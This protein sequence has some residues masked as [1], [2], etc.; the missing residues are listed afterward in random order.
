MKTYSKY[1]SL[2]F[3]CMLLGACSS[4]ENAADLYRQESPLQAD[5]T[6]PEEF[7]GGVP[8]KIYLTQDEKTIDNADFVHVEIWKSDGS[9]R[10]PME[11]A[12]NAGNGN[13]TFDKTLTEDG[14]YYIKVHAGNN[15]STIMPTLPFAVGELSK[16]DVKTLEG[17]VPDDSGDHSGH[18]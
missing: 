1:F 17:Q 18:H 6:M 7:S 15:G 8:I 9:F 4:K 13:Y 16:D 2:I 10:N 3:I 14:L 5:I 11:E 12:T